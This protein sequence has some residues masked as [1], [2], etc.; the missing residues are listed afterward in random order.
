MH[1]EVQEVRLL[2]MLDKCLLCINALTTTL[3][4]RVIIIRDNIHIIQ[5]LK[6]VLRN[7]EIEH[8]SGP[9]VLRMLH[10]TCH[11]LMKLAEDREGAYLIFIEETGGCQCIK[12]LIE[13]F[14]RNLGDSTE[15]KIGK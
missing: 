8:S 3:D 14:Q 6:Q 7:L 9:Q 5:I 10:T 2:D 13:R 12:V 15:G 1:F 11:I 4:N